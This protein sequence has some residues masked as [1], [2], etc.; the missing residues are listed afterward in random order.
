[1][2][3][4]LLQLMQLLQFWDTKEFAMSITNNFIGTD[5]SLTDMSIQGYDSLGF[6][7]WSLTQDVLQGQFTITTESPIP[8][9]SYSDNFTWAKYGHQILFCVELTTAKCQLTVK[10][11]PSLN[12]MHCETLIAFL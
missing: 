11:N 2:Q 12:A 5:V 6:N 3:D 1:M 8:I 7:T 4:C 9:T 10:C